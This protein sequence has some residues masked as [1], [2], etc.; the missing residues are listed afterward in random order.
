MIK[1][2]SLAIFALR[3]QNNIPWI[4]RNRAYEYSATYTPVTYVYI[5]FWIKNPEE[6]KS[7]KSKFGPR[8]KSRSCFDGSFL[9]SMIVY[10]RT[11]ILNG[12]RINKK[13][14][15]CRL[16]SIKELKRVKKVLC[17]W[18]FSVSFHNF[19]WNR[20]DYWY[21]RLH[22]AIVFIQRSM[23]RKIVSLNRDCK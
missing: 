1:R 8:R 11:K 12:K 7:F 23:T 3:Y 17:W 2:A 19:P 13:S 16:H 20:F 6:K 15:S 5:Y 14:K 10:E 18:F 21:R 9:D 4:P 22:F